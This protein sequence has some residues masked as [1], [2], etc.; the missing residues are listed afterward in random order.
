[1]TMPSAP[2][3]L[4]VGA[5]LTGTI[6]A[7]RLLR[8]GV[9]H[10][11]LWDSAGV[12]GGR[13]RSEVWTASGAD[14]LTDTGA[15]Y[16]TMAEGVQAIPAHAELFSELRE[17]GLLVP[18]TG[19]IDGGRAADGGGT[20]YVSPD[21]LAA[22]VQWLLQESAPSQPRVFLGRTVDRLDLVQAGGSARWR[23]S[24][25]LASGGDTSGGDTS[26]DVSGD[27]S[28]DASCGDTSRDASRDASGTSD[29]DAVVLTPPAPQLLPLLQSGDGAAWLDA[30]MAGTLRSSLQALQYSSRY[31][32]SLFF[33]SSA[34]QSF[35][36]K[37][38]WVASYPE[39]DPILVFL[40]LDSAKRGT[41]GAPTL[42]AH[43]SVPFGLQ[44]VQS[45]T[46]DQQVQAEMMAAVHRRLPWLP[47]PI[48]IRLHTWRVSQM[49]RSLQGL[50]ADRACLAVPPPGAAPE[51]GPP[52]ILAGDAFSV[53]GSRF[54]G[55]VQSGEDAAATL[56]EALGGAK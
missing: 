32:L 20:N 5:G 38:D 39:G 51:G 29:F 30:G 53:H 48:G 45:G 26:R 8:S 3:V 25:G 52:L 10:V 56:L 2:R 28:G 54:D 33:D 49:R 18:M 46:S 22:L 6:V 41:T 9:S 43:S 42:L 31:A 19:R 40:S 16:V 4:I 13:M 47:P 50:P 44:N 35:A 55:C 23:V 34:A 12:V 1:M 14:L 21:G 17:A 36:D 11:E 27:A 15:Q 24:Y 7:R 37:I